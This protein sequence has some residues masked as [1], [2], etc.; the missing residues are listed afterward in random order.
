MP[1]SGLDEFALVD[2]T[3]VPRVD[4][5]AGGPGDDSL[6]RTLEADVV[7]GGD[8]VGA[9]RQRGDLERTVLAGGDLERAEAALEAGLADA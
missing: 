2:E 8:V 5:H 6:D 7:V 4:D 9:R 3:Q 1:S